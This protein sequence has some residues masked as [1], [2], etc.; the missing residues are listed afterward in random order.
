MLVP[1]G[2]PEALAQANGAVLRDPAQ[3]R[4]MGI[5][6]RQRVEH[7]YDI[8]KMMA[9][10]EWMYS[11]PLPLGEGPGGREGLRS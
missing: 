7:N 8:R 6:G 10:Y 3:G 4:K 5:A 1:A 2:D 9:Q 11:S